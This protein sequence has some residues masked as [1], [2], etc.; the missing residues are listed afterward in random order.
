MLHT[1][2]VTLNGGP[3][4]QCYHSDPH[5]FCCV[6]VCPKH[7]L[8]E[9]EQG[10]RFAVDSSS[11]ITVSFTPNFCTTLSLSPHTDPILLLFSIT[12]SATQKNLHMFSRWKDRNKK[13]VTRNSLHISHF[14]HVC[15]V[16]CPSHL[17]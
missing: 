16:P 14:S 2:L 9:L 8:G 17:S 5:I 13:F 4:D 6:L 1:L 12:Y 15:F 7:C 3:I 11:L 10:L